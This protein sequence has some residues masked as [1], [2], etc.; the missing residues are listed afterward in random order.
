[1][2]GP[3]KKEARVM[4][5]ARAC[6]YD[7][8]RDYARLSLIVEDAANVPALVQSLSASPSLNLLRAKNRLD[9][10]HDAHESA[11]YRDYQLLACA[12]GG[13]G[14]IVEIQVIPGEMYMLKSTLGHA[15]YSKYRFILEACRRAKA[16]V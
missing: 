2:V 1:M 9:P 16:R 4:Q 3:P 6:D 12:V 11:G 14:W 8:I 5:K 15:G 7:S 13:P 10:D